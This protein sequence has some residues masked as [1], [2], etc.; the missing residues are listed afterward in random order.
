MC[1]RF[2]APLNLQLAKDIAIVPF[3]RVQ[4]QEQPLANLLIR[5]A[6]RNKVE[7]FYL[8]VAQRLDQGLGN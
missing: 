7:D 5:E 6:L 8:A 1:D 2:G 4:G 3:D